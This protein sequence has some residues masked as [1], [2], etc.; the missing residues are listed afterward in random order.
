MGGYY[1]RTKL[2]A[3]NWWR[4]GFC[5]TVVYYKGGMAPNSESPKGQQFVRVG[6]GLRLINSI[7]YWPKHLR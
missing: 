1:Y 5:L 4:K 7:T 6:K 2:I 3:K